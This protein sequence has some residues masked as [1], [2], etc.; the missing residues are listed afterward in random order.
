LEDAALAKAKTTALLAGF[1]KDLDGTAM[2]DIKAG[3]PAELSLEPGTIRALPPGAD[4]TF[5]PT[6]D[7]TGIGE[8]LK[9]FLRSIASGT[10]APYP[11][12]AENLS[13]VNYSSARVGLQNFWR[14]CAAIR[15]SLL[16]NR[17]LQPIYER[18]VTLEILSGRLVVADFERN[19]KQYFRASFLFPVPVSI[20]PVK[21]TSADTMAIDAG[22]ASREQVIAARG[23]DPDEVNA[24]IS[25]DTFQP[26]ILATPK[27]QVN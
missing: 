2:P 6:S 4:I 15:S 3:N 14:R 24:E 26:K 25:R 11:L 13:D 12:I 7:F 1:L 9:H 21:D 18:F 17:L 8:L 20:D 23:R 10:G 27:P 19:P 16:I 22:I 5:S